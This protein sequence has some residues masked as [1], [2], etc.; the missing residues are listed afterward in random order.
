MASKNN[1]MNAHSNNHLNRGAGMAQSFRRLIAL[2]AIPVLLAACTDD[3]SRSRGGGAAE[4]SG[5]VVKGVTANAVVSIY[6]PGEEGPELLATTMSNAQGAFSVTL[7]RGFTGAVK[8]VATASAPPEVPTQMRCDATSGCGATPD[9]STGDLN[10]NSL[11]DYGEWFEVPADFELTAVASVTGAGLRMINV[12]P[13]STMAAAWAEKFPQG[14][15][16]RSADAANEQVAAMFGFALVDL[17][18]GT[19]DLTD[20]MWL[21]LADAKQI[22]LALLYATFAEFAAANELD[23]QDVIDL[24]AQIFADQEG[25]LLQD[26]GEYSLAALLT[27]TTTMAGVIDLPDE[28]DAYNQAR[29]DIDA[30]LASLESGAMTGHV[31]E[32]SFDHLLTRLGPLGTDLD[33]LLGITGLD[34]PLQFILEQGPQFAW[35]LADEN[36]QIVPLGLETVMYSLMAALQMDMLP[37]SVSSVVLLSDGYSTITLNV[38]AKT[39]TIVGDRHGQTVNLTV[40]LTGFLT[41]A[42]TG[43]FDFGID[44]TAVNAVAAGEIHG[45]LSVDTGET[46]FSPLLSAIVAMKTGSP[47]AGLQFKAALLGLANSLTADVTLSGNAQLVNNSNTDSVL[48]GEVVLTAFL[49]LGAQEGETI[50]NLNVASG[51]IVLP[52]G[53]RLYGLGDT[54]VLTVSV[55]DDAALELDGAATLF[56]I[57]EATLHL[58][59]ELANVRPLFDHV[60]STLLA[61]I[62]GESSSADFAEL[63]EKLLDFDFSAMSLSASGVIEIDELGHQY[64]AGIE[65]MTATVYQPFSEEVAASA[66]LDLDNQAVHMVLGDEP[67]DLR[68]LTTPTPRLVLLGP[69]GQ[70]GEATQEDVYAFLELLPLGD[71]LGGLFPEVPET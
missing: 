38:P 68:V 56:N 55:G 33:E 34:N 26:G 1:K 8:V 27:V 37:G 59:G 64:R 62:S 57:P 25:S 36:L 13:L 16:A 10:E 42:Q 49:D 2:A 29:D 50:A 12:T 24:L 41:G 9:G 18:Q 22:Q 17:E 48:A 4:I 69:D 60:R 53:D 35:L 46:N 66:T 21:G 3:D 31:Q 47:T 14:L 65:N 71:L 67:W 54:P 39:L 6:A 20:E 5:S 61:E 28:P 43:R 32:I 45:T 52:N 58:E 15:D 40:A 44:G 51:E 30:L 19:G 23:M 63:I 11:V 7:P 70:F